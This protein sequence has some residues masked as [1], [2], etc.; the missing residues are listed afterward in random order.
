MSITMENNSL[1]ERKKKWADIFAYGE[2]LSSKYK[3]T[4]SD[5]N[6]EINNIKELN[7]KITQTPIVINNGNQIR[8]INRSIINP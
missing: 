6:L 4:E 8:E 3:F 1:M 7:K 2:R 5:V